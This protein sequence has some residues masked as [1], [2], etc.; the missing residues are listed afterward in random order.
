MHGARC[1]GQENRAGVP[2]VCSK[3]RCVRREGRSA[4]P[5]RALR[6]CRPDRPRHPRL[7]KRRP[8]QFLTAVEG[9]ARSGHRVCADGR[10]RDKRDAC[11]ACRAP[12]AGCRPGAHAAA[13]RALCAD[14]M[15]H[16]LI[17]EI[18]RH[19]QQQKVLRYDRLR[20]WVEART[21]RSAA[22]Q[23]I[24]YGRRSGDIFFPCLSGPGAACGFPDRLDAPSW[25]ARESSGACA[26]SCMS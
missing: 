3:R 1:R 8:R 16:E 20:A 21:G 7:E 13:C 17:T 6:Q 9:L 18:C 26:R 15:P 23:P 10:C 14:A 24:D 4:R 5:G 11:R 12:C 22:M 25:A 19:L 2:P